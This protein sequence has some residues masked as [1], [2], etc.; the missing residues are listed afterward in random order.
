M[1]RSPAAALEVDEPRL[2]VAN[3]H[4]AALE[5]A[6]HEGRR[7][8]LQEDVGQVVEVVL[9]AVFLK[10]KS[11]GLEE[12]VFE[13][14]QI[15]KDGA[16]VKLGFG[17]A[18]GKV[19]VL[20]TGYLYGGQKADGLAQEL[21]FFFAED[22]CLPGFAEDAE[23]RGVSQVFLEIIEIVGRAG[24]DLR[25]GQSLPAEVGGHVEKGAVFVGRF[26]S[27]AYQRRGAC[28]SEIASVGA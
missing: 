27:D 6:V 17:I 20:G 21:F 9:Q 16:F 25:H 4:V 1:D 11:G 15:P 22:A 7:V 2:A 26:S 10:I 5:V 18:V 8:A 12:A 14:V 13:V 23:Q 3:H 24:K 28:Q 19:Y